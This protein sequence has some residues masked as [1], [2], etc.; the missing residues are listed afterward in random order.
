MAF[1]YGSGQT[2]PGFEDERPIAQ[3]LQRAGDN[4]LR[5]IGFLIVAAATLLPWALL[6][7]LL[8]WLWRQL[9]VGAWLS[10]RSDEAFAR[11]Q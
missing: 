1:Y 2:V 6:V 3:A 7:G 5:A 4:F 11:E 10:R 9:R 8:V